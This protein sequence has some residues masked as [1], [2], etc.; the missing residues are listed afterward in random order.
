M[1]KEAFM[2]FH[3]FLTLQA[4]WDGTGNE[5]G[6]QGDGFISFLGRLKQSASLYHF[7]VAIT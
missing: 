3:F 7:Q 5:K 1:V 4:R 6:V 2:V